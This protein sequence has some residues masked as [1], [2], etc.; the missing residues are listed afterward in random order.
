[1]RRLVAAA[2]AAALIASPAL[3]AESANDFQLYVLGDLT[4]NGQNIGNRVA[5][6][7]DAS[8]SSTSIGGATADMPASLVVGGDLTYVNGGSIAGQALV[9]GAD[10]ALPYLPVVAGQSNLPVDFTV[11]NLR[12][13]NLSATLAGQAATGS[14]YVQWGG[15]FLNGQD[16]GLNVFSVTTAMLSQVSWFSASIASGSQ[17]LI[18]VT[19]DAANLSGGLD[20]FTASNVLWNFSDATSITAGGVSLGGSIL[21]PNAAFTGNGGTIQ[22]NLIA[23]SFNGAMSF[24][25]ALY[26]GD[27]LTPLAAAPGDPGRPGVVAIPEPGVW[28]LMILGFGAVGTMLRRRRA[29][30]RLAALAA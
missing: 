23:G 19:G 18:N 7:G 28:A 3:A 9:G 20:F 10:N 8:F 30:D 1:M 22:G 13:K 15:L 12:L 21:A 5:V 26:G 29:A 17:V 16:A 2:A 11:E 6:G 24:G 27:L 14:A 25:N 4:M